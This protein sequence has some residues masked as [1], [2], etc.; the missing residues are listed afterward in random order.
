M[1]TRLVQHLA[2]LCAV[3]AGGFG[4]VVPAQAAPANEPAVCVFKTPMHFSPGISPED[5]T[6][7]RYG[8]D[9]N[10]VG[11]ERGDA[12]CI[13]AIGGHRITGV[14][15]FGFSGIWSE[16]NCEANKGAGHY[17]FTVST[18]AGQKR[19]AGKY[20]EQRVGFNG[21]VTASQPEGLFTGVF[22][23]VP[24]GTLTNLETCHRKPITK[25]TLVITGLFG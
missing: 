2:G 14:G 19:F 20:T 7:L 10:F 5:W 21:T 18:T 22:N 1:R 6:G 4:V 12:A 13:G 9:E 3:A 8:S 11:A 25:A 17:S 24:T 16:G 15:T 23:I